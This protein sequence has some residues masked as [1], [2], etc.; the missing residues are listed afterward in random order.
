MTSDGE[1]HMLEVLLLS[2]STF[3]AFS[4][5][6]CP[7]IFKIIF[8]IRPDLNRCLLAYRGDPRGSEAHLSHLSALSPLPSEHTLNSNCTVRSRLEEAAPARRRPRV[9]RGDA[10][11]GR[12]AAAGARARAQARAA[13]LR[14]LR[15]GGAVPRVGTRARLP[16]GQRGHRLR[17]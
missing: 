10:C 2:N 15:R 14:A 3:I 13:V 9:A 11:A 1:C 16:E 8:N 6:S 7:L 12:V 4:S 17:E 5:G